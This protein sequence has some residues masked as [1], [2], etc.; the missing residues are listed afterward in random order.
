MCGCKLTTQ[1]PFCDGTTC[2]KILNNEP[3]VE[4]QAALEEAAAAQTQIE[5]QQQ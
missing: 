5:G 3:F 1:A 2:K 4:A